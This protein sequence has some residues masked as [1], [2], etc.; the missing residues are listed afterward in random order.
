MLTLEACRDSSDAPAPLP[1]LPASAIS[2]LDFPGSAAV[3]TTMRFRFLNPLAIYRIHLACLSETTGR[4]LHGVFLG[5]RRRT[6]KSPNIF[7]D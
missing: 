1:A 4:I 5:Q 2:G 6:G 3:V 7:M